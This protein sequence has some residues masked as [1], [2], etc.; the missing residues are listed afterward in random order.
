MRSRAG[1]WAARVVI[2]PGIVALAGAPGVSGPPPSMPPPPVVAEINFLLAALGNS[3]CEYFRNGAWYSARQAQAHLDGK[4]QWLVA[5]DRVRT[6]EDF[7][8]LAATRSS[9]SGRAYAVRCAGEEPV[10]SNSWLAGQLRRY[11]DAPGT[12]HAGRGAP[13]AQSSN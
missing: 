7:I 4:Y 10:S 1:S 3:G 6:A 5:R 9:V 11:R 13:V 2:L 12:P 8:E